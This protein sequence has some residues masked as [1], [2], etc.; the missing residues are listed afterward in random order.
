IC[1]SLNLVFFTS[2]SSRRWTLAQTGGV[3]GEHVSA[4]LVTGGTSGIG[5]EISLELVRRGVRK[6]VIVARETEKLDQVSEEIAALEPACEVHTIALDL[7]ERDAGA[8]VRQN[9]DEKGWPVEILVNDAGFARKYV[10]A[11]NVESDPSLPMVDLMVRAVVDLSLQ[12]LPDMVKRGRGGILN[13]GSTA[14]YSP[15]PFTSVYA[16]AKAFVVSFSKAVREENRD[17]GVRIACIVPGITDTNLAGDGHGEKRGTLDLVGIDNPADVA[18]GAVDVLEANEA[19]R[20]F[21]WNNK[22][23]AAAQGVLPDSA[24]AYLVAKSRG[25]PGDED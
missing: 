2:I 9:V 4:A 17:T 14:A 25:R 1:S 21:G 11:E 7:A 19:A 16:A 13:L 3:S 10:F 18:K 8:K 20:T 24:N 12:F 5:K 22:L 15:V 23:L 6:L